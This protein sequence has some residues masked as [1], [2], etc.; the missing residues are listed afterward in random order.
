MTP[1]AMLLAMTPSVYS[2]IDHRP[3]LHATYHVEMVALGFIT[4]IGLTRFGAVSGRVVFRAVG[5]NGPDVRCR[6]EWR[7]R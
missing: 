4:G 3:L 6:S 2:G 5:W 7:L 1:A